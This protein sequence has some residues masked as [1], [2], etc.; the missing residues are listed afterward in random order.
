MLNRCIIYANDN[1][2][3]YKGIITSLKLLCSLPMLHFAPAQQPHTDNLTSP[4]NC[5]GHR[6]HRDGNDIVFVLKGIRG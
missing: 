3:Y 5:T 1:Y 6:G 4:R 2:K